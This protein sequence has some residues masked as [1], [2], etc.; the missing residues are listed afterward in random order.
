MLTYSALASAYLGWV[1]IRGE[2]VGS[3]SWP[4]VLL[5]VVITILLGRAWLHEARD[6]RT[7]HTHQ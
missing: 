2:W 6:R 1:G 5:H 4:A 7:D 3:V